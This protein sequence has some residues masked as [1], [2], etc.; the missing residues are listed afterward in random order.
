MKRR[1]KARQRDPGK[2]GRHS[3]GARP[4][5]P[6]GTP[7]ERRFSQ[8]GYSLV[9]VADSKRAHSRRRFY[10]LLASL[11]TTLISGSILMVVCGIAMTFTDL[12]GIVHKYRISETA[13][14]IGFCGGLALCF[15]GA[16]LTIPAFRA[17]ERKNLEE[18]RI[19]RPTVSHQ[20]FDRRYST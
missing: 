6:P 1:K 15:I 10:L 16:I 17:E 5:Y 19:Y 20:L 4:F 7:V 11:L 3:Y 2:G 9:S 18:S 14:Q 8:R 12:D 13:I